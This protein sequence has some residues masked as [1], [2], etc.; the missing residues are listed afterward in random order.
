MLKYK[1]NTNMGDKIFN[2]VVLGNTGVG[3]SSLLNFLSNNKE[4]FPEGDTATSVTSK[5]QFKVFKWMG[6]PK[7]QNIRFCD[8]QGLSDSRGID[9]ENI[10]QMIAT[11]KD[12][13]YVSLFLICFNGD[14][15]RFSDYTKST[16]QL[17]VDMFGKDFLNHV[18]LV[19]NK[20]Y[21]QI[22]RLEDENRRRSEF[23]KTIEENFGKKEVPCFF[24]DSQCNLKLKRPNPMTG[25]EEE[26]NLPKKIQ[27][28]TFAQIYCLYAWLISKNAECDVRNAIAK[29]TELEEMRSKADEA[30]QQVKQ[31]EAEVTALQQKA[32]TAEEKAF[33]AQK[34]A[35]AAIFRANAEKN[36]V[37][38]H[39]AAEIE[40]KKAEMAEQRAKDL[41]KHYRELEKIKADQI[42]QHNLQTQKAYERINQLEL[43]QERQ[44]AKYES[45]RTESESYSRQAELNR[46]RDNEYKSKED[47][48]ICAVL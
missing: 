16:I 42:M 41:E 19:F 1:N 44:R 36:K 48:S 37:E 5:A 27:D 26:S 24:I 30:S 33:A 34:Q 12:L 17:F 43:E 40:K 15:P 29:K 6:D 32:N 22:K 21:G 20:W 2:I 10:K 28:K 25:E 4:A 18:V 23:Q 38:A 3:K 35:E 39:L 45:S 47:S 14:E 8:T 9:T 46:L 7:N 11:I 31:M 13:Q